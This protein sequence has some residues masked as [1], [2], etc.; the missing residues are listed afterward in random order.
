MLGISAI[1]LQIYASQ[2]SA[3]AKTS[4]VELQNCSSSSGIRIT[5]SSSRLQ[6]TQLTYRSLGRFQQETKDN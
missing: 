4:A 5:I 2:L 1:H 6:T 3:E